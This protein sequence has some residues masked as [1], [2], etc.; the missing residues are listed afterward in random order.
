[1]RRL[2]IFA[3]LLVAALMVSLPA[4]AQDV[5]TTLIGGGPNNI[6]ALDANLYYPA[7]VAVDTAGNYY[8]AAYGQN[9]VFKVSTGGTITVVAGTAGTTVVAYGG[10][11]VV[12]PGV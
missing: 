11:M 7:G 8:I 2:T 9:R 3:A 4:P 12:Y 5:I 10:P 6:P 1:M